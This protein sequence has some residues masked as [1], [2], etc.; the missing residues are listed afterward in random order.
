MTEK[1][2]ADFRKT[3]Y[4][5]SWS[6]SLIERQ[7]VPGP[8]QFLPQQGSSADMD[9]GGS[10]GGSGTTSGQDMGTKSSTNDTEGVTVTETAIDSEKDDER[11]GLL[12]A[13]KQAN[14]GQGAG[15]RHSNG[16]EGATAT[17]TAIDVEKGLYNDQGDEKRHL[18]EAE[19]HDD[20]VSIVYLCMYIHYIIDHNSTC[21][22]I[23]ISYSTIA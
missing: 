5:G 11:R 19:K 2:P 22:C 8:F 15:G 17:G 9:P 1:P 20:K 14:S 13:E 12:E 10:T 7:G 16:G 21:I 23:D 3:A 18:L 4:R 6:A